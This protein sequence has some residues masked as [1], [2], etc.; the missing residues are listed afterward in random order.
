VNEVNRHDPE[1]RAYISAMVSSS[2][3]RLHSLRFP[4]CQ[5]GTEN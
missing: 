2:S 1:K 4:L 3:I 5:S